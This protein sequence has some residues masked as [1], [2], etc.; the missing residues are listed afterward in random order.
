MPHRR[1]LLS[2]VAEPPPISPLTTTLQIVVDREMTLP[3]LRLAA[4]RR[5]LSVPRLVENLL[6]AIVAWDEGLIDAVLGADD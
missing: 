1:P 3:T 4:A 2:Y 5:D 6:G